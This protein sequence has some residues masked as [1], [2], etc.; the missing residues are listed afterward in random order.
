MTS[1]TRAARPLTFVL[2]IAALLASG[3]ARHD[4]MNGAAAHAQ[5]AQGTV[6]HVG[7]QRGGSLNLLRLRGDLERRLAPKGVTVQWLNFPAGPQL[8][9]GIGANSVDIGSAGDTPPIFA[10]AAGVPLVYV[11]NT[12]PSPKAEAV[13]Q[14]LIVPK[15]S[16]AKTLQDLRGKKIAFQKGSSANYFLVQA[17]GQVGL[18]YSDVQPTYLSPPDAQAAFASGSIDGWVIWDPFLSIARHTT[19]ARILRDGANLPTSGGFYLAS[20]TFAVE[21]PDL[22][23]AVLEEAKKAGDWSH[24]HSHEAAQ[25]LSPDLGLDV[26]TL[27]QI[28]R[29]G[30]TTNYREITPEV[31]ALQ[32][33]EADAFANIGLI[34]Q[35]I[36]VR[37]ATLTPEQ[38][39]RLAPAQ[40][41]QVAEKI[42]EITR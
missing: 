8:L 33:K 12:P 26:P 24:D 25:I 14:A 29:N 7:Y 30:Y 15:D 37:Q 36:D 3:C 11:A 9:E 20:R 39:A 18:K 21:H 34:P 42:K 6:L 40:E 19:G 1:R 17:L 41:P 10:Q 23:K 22:V 16:P 13:G 31:I 35:K 38:Y 2:G 4:G 27:E 5:S 28:V 32:Q